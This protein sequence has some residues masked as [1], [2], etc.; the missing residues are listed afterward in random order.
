MAF[1]AAELPNDP[2]ALKQEIARLQTVV[3]SY[4]VAKEQ[5]RKEAEAAANSPAANFEVEV[6]TAKSQLEGLIDGSEDYADPKVRGDI[7][8]GAINLLDRMQAALPKA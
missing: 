6:Y 1:N 4:E 3:R 2:A 7:C 8:R 5:R